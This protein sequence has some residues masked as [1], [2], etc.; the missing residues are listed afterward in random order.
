[1]SPELKTP[2]NTQDQ[3]PTVNE[4]PVT[5]RTSVCVRKLEVDVK[6]LLSVEGAGYAW[7]ITVS[8]I[9]RE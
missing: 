5:I 4:R 6:L 7:G 8:C 2:Q 9:T 3:R 1:M